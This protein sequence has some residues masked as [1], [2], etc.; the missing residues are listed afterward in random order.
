MQVFDISIS[1]HDSTS[2]VFLVGRSQGQQAHLNH[3]IGPG[4]FKSHSNIFKM[5]FPCFQYLL[6]GILVISKVPNFFNG[7][8][9]GLFEL[10]RDQEGSQTYELEF[11]NGNGANT[12]ENSCSKADNSTKLPKLQQIQ[13]VT[14][15]LSIEYLTLPI[16]C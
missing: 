8:C 13:L 14:V 15:S 2:N 16:G 1:E 9:I 7:G 4:A 10:G 3:P 11:G 12:Q 6:H 5:Y